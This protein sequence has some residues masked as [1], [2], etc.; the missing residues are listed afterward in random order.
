MTG[1]SRGREYKNSPALQL[2]FVMLRASDRLAGNVP[3]PSYS[4]IKFRRA[5]SEMKRLGR[6]YGPHQ[7]SVAPAVGKVLGNSD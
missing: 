2:Q 6:H 3:L 7:I 4:P 1:Q 5:A